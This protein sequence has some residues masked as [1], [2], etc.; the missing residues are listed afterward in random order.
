VQGP[1]LVE[2]DLGAPAN[3]I[4]LG[5]AFVGLTGLTWALLAFSIGTVI[6]GAVL[7]GFGA[8]LLLRRWVRVES[9]GAKITR[10]QHL[11][12]FPMPK[13]T[14]EAWEPE[15]VYLADSDKGVVVTVDLPVGSEPVAEMTDLDRA[16]ELA[17]ATAQVLGCPFGE[18]EDV[19]GDEDLGDTTEE[20]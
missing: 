17:A 13:D 4:G 5:L 19:P 9:E 3:P 1:E 2:A 12:G 10:G 15:R 18:S 20:E 8:L 16:R 14:V 6:F 11:F 7:A